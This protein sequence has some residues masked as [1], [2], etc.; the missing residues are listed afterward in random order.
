MTETAQI[1][2]NGQRL[3]KQEISSQINFW[4]W[5]VDQ[6]EIFKGRVNGGGGCVCIGF[7]GKG[8]VLPATGCHFFFFL[9]W[10]GT[11]C[12]GTGRCVIQHD[13]VIMSI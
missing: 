6:G 5:G 7:L 2:F 1:L 4:G 8:R 11:S 9:L 10:S 12:H 3:E 13:I